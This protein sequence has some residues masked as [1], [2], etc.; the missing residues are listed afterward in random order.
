MIREGKGME[1][2][3][4]GGEM[5]GQERQDKTVL[6]FQGGDISRGRTE[7]TRERK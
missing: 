5:R 1:W 3:G 7:K 2:N 4:R 6:K